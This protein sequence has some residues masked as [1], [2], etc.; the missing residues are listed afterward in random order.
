MCVWGEGGYIYNLWNVKVLNE[1]CHERN[2]NVL[3]EKRASHINK[4]SDNN[5]NN[6]N[7][8]DITN[9][10]STQAQYFKQGDCLSCR[11]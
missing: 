2:E 10:M 9:S 4:N 6:N 8:T 5:N 11:K 1:N 3:A 7:N